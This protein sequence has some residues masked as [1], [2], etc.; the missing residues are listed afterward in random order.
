[1][2]PNALLLTFEGK[3][4]GPKNR[5]KI[6]RVWTK[7]LETTQNYPKTTQKLPD[8]VFFGNVEKNPKGP[9]FGVKIF[10]V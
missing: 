3:N 5:S 4:F 6:Q 7:F 9:T 8:F 10:L 2:D 1:M